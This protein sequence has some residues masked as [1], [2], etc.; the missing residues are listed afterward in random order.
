MIRNIPWIAAALM[1]T[2]GVAPAWAADA[3]A[4]KASYD[5]LCANCHGAS[6]KG[7]GPTGAAFPTKPRDFSDATWQASVDDARIAKAIT[8]GG[9]AVGLTPFMPPFAQL[10]AVEVANIVAYIRSLSG[11]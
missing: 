5:G 6:G 11:K 10:S 2:M 3:A 8:G 4:G 9:P 7:D 1:A